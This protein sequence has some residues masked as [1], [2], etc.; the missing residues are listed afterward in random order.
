MKVYHE[1]HDIKCSRKRFDNNVAYLYH[2]PAKARWQ[3]VQSKV[4]FVAS[5]D[6]R[7]F[8]S[9]GFSCLNI[10][11]YPSLWHKVDDV[12]CVRVNTN[13]RVNGTYHD[14]HISGYEALLHLKTIICGRRIEL[15]L[16]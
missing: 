13:T 15:C 14:H 5:D 8:C 10:A 6:A 12:W 7:R 16:N 2:G 4:A 1:K 11:L 9:V 3:V